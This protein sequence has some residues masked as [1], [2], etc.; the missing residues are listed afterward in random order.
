MADID[1]RKKLLL[2]R[3]KGEFTFLEDSVREKTEPQLDSD[4]F[5]GNEAEAAIDMLRTNTAASAFE[6]KV[7]KIV[8]GLQAPSVPEKDLTDAEVDQIYAKI[9]ADARSNDTTDI[10]RA[11][12]I[13]RELLENRENGD[14][15]KV[16]RAKRKL[17]IIRNGVV[18]VL[19][20]QGDW[21]IDFYLAA[22][23]VATS[24][25]F[26]TAKEAVEQVRAERKMGG[27]RE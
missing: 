6:D 11:L 3:L 13:I 25:T 22:E 9:D 2:Y 10:T 17:K 8:L 7:N 23:K 26:I 12:G 14:E 19:E 5:Y 20:Q 21:K 16:E 1:P 18:N 27:G 15:P 4:P 24:D